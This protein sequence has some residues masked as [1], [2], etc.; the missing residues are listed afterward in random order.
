[1]GVMTT[2]PR[3]VTGQVTA[4][5]ETYFISD[6]TTIYVKTLN[7]SEYGLSITAMGINLPIK[8]GSTYKIATGWFNSLVSITEIPTV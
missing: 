5:S 3:S 1:M 2:Y 7:G 4:I 6:S 8:I